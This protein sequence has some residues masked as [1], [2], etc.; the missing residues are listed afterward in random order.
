M[1]RIHRLKLRALP[2]TRVKYQPSPGD[3]GTAGRLTGGNQ[4]NCNTPRT[5]WYSAATMGAATA[6]LDH[7]ITS[8]GH[9]GPDPSYRWGWGSGNT[10]TE[11]PG[12]PPEVLGPICITLSRDSSPKTDRRAPPPTP[13]VTFYVRPVRT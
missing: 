3:N 2:L 1:T 7:Q 12:S 6:A 10:V 9:H 4:R 13:G 11:R 5:P 8:Y